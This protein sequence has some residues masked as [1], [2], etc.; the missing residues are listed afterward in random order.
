MSADDASGRPDGGTVAHD[1]LP[2]TERSGSATLRESYVLAR[3]VAYKSLILRIRYAFNTVTNLFTIYVFFAL[4]FFGGR[5]IA[6][7]AITDSLTGIIVGFFLILMAT[8]A[9]SDLSWELIR[10]AQWGTLE[11]LYMSP[12]GFRRVVFLKTAV[13]LVVAFA[14][15]AIL[16]GLM[17]LTTGTTLAL[18]PLTVV[19]LGLL[20]MGPAV[21]VGYVLGG[22]A[23]L[24]KRVENVFQIVQFSFV[25]L[26]AAPVDTYPLLKL[27]PLALGA[28]LLRDA[29]GGGLRLWELPVADLGLL[30]LKAVLYVAVGHILFGWFARRARDGGKLGK[31]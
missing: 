5:A 21:G 29:M 25:G 19:P 6:P 20:A 10:E 18:D 13:N 15:G 24:F 23:L 9:Y 7:Q 3:A 14:F 22:L 4:L 30:V 31:Y 1:P 12:L 27:L 8:V 16:L 17:L 28:D 11:Q 2:A 26:V